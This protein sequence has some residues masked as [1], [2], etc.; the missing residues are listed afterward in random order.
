MCAGSNVRNPIIVIFSGKHGEKISIFVHEPVPEGKTPHITY[1][2]WPD[3]TPN[4]TWP[5]Y[6]GQ[7]FTVDVYGDFDAVELFL[8]NDSMGRQ[9]A[10]KQERF[11]ASFSVPYTP[12]TLKAVG[13][14]DGMPVVSKDLTTT[15]APAQIRLSP[16]RQTLKTGSGD[17]S[18]ITVEVTDA[19]GN[20]HRQADHR[21]FYTLK[22]PGNA[23]GCR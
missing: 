9:A 1:W 20:L 22:G 12:G 18:Y 15:G 16:D 11:T 7:V 13:I 6:E 2:G 17:L 23:A 4:W 8:N 5:G 21:I 19:A 3:V 10:T 14:K